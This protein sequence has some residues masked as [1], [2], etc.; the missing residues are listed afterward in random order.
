M[1]ISDS[2]VKSEGK[3]HDG[4]SLKSSAANNEAFDE[5]DDTE[6]EESGQ[7]D[8]E[9][10]DVELTEKPSLEKMNE[11][12][13][14]C[15]KEQQVE[16]NSNSTLEEGVEEKCLNKMNKSKSFKD[17]STD[18]INDC[19]DE[20]EKM[21]M[22][23]ETVQVSSIIAKNLRQYVNKQDFSDDDDSAS[24]TSSKSRKLNIFFMLYFD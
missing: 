16:T 22:N 17:I 4:H 24:T 14:T 15:L 21:R 1:K 23:D 11:C 20:N 3:E 9:T 5:Y 12:N 10:A 8:C 2:N 13:T 6:E 19:V 7:S 18:I